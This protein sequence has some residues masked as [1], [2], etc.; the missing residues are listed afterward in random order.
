LWNVKEATQPADP[1][2]ANQ[3]FS[4]LALDNESFKIDKLSDKIPVVRNH[5]AEQNLLVALYQPEAS[6]CLRRVLIDNARKHFKELEKVE[7]NAL[8]AH[9]S[10][11]ERMLD[12]RLEEIFLKQEGYG[13]GMQF[14]DGKTKITFKTFCN[15]FEGI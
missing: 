3:P 8:L 6:Y 4:E 13:K 5:L 10:Q 1:N 11:R 9:S 14:N 2:A 12:E 15:S 7:M